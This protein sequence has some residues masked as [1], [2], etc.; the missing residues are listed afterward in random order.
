MNLCFGDMYI[1]IA[2]KYNTTSFCFYCFEQLINSLIMLEC[3]YLR[4]LLYFVY[5]IKYKKGW[6]DNQLLRILGLNIESNVFPIRTNASPVK[7][8]NKPGGISHHHRPLE[9]AAAVWAS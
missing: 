9:A 8:I 1:C 2:S 3:K 6:I 4:F 5:Y 7:A